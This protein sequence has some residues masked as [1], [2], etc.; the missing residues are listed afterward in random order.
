MKLNKIFATALAILTLTACDDDDPVNTA[1]VT[2]NMQETTMTVA[3]DIQTGIYYNVPVVLSGETNGPVTVTVEVEGIGSDPATEGEDYVITS[4]TIVI[5]AGKTTGSIEFHSTGDTEVNE[6]R[7][8]TMTIV[9]ATGAKIG[10]NATTRIILFDDDHLL[11]EALAKTVGTWSTGAGYN[12]E[13]VALPE[14]D[15]DHFQKVLLRGINGTSRT[16][17]LELGFSLDAASGCVNLTLACPQY[18]GT[19]DFNGIGTADVQLLPRD[20]DGLYISGTLSATSDVDIT[21]FA[22]DMGISGGLFQPGTSSAGGF[23]GYTWFNVVPLTLT[24]VQ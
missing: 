7:E 15:P 10:S 23:L 4:K 16:S 5:P 21:V 6:S 13:L 8:F 1:D 12:V 18:V 14:D 20:A 2:V 9:S 22:F 3:E 11:P 24:K 17:D 19:F